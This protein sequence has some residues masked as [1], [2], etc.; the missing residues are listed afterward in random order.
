MKQGNIVEQLLQ[1]FNGATWDG[2]LISKR[3]RDKLVDD[4][5]VKQIKGWNI[6]TSKGASYLI[7]LNF[8]SP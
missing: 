4:G 5:L 3:I 1:I 8:V 7:D 2:N 6:I